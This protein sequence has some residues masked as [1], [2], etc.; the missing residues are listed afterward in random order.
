MRLQDH[1]IIVKV[2]QANVLTTPRLNDFISNYKAIAITSR[3]ENVA[4]AVSDNAVPDSSRYFA[5]IQ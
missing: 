4:P 5:I 3:W 2:W 1:I